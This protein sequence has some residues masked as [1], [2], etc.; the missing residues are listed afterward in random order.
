M[1]HQS[2]AVA[3]GLV[4][5]IAL[6]GCL[7][8]L[9]PSPPDEESGALLPTTP[10]SR[11]PEGAVLESVTLNLHLQS[12]SGQTVSLHRINAPWDEGNVHWANFGGSY[13]E[14]VVASFLVDHDGWFAVDFTALALSWSAGEAENFGL[15]LRHEPLATPRS[16]FP[17]R[18]SATN[19]PFIE[20]RAVADGQSVA[21]TLALAAD[22]FIWQAMPYSMFGAATPL[23][24]GWAQPDPGIEMQ[25]LVRFDL[26]ELPPADDPEDDPQDDPEDPQ[27]EYGCTFTRA[28]WFWMSRHSRGFWEDQ[29]TPL[30]PLWLGEPDGENSR[31]VSTKRAAR[32][33]LAWRDYGRWGNGILHLRSELLAAKLNVARGASDF[34]VAETIAA[35]DALLAEYGVRDW[36][37]AGPD[38][39]EEVGAL[40][41][42]LRAWN[43]G[44]TGPGRCEPGTQAA[45][46]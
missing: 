22:A 45:G 29:V 41:L 24:A 18:E 23:Y 4:L 32:R 12:A 28:A 21:D 6:A 19:A 33:V 36:Y 3:L 7:P 5:A 42:A 17:S 10:P 9:G 16:I 11:L 37:G 38:L 15:L 40:K 31:L 30:L 26:P 25:T 46:D 43:R 27:E 34:S 1:R 8:V 44:E 2:S 20:I 14:E 13:D 39:R 35:A